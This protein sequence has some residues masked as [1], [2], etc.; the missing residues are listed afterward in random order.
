MAGEPIESD[1]PLSEEVVQA[2][3][4]YPEDATF[5]FAWSG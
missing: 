4:P 1:L 3:V 5:V 2:V